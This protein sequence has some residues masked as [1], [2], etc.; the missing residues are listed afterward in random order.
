VAGPPIGLFEG[1]GYECRQ[2]QLQPGDGL[3]LFSDGVTEAMDAQDHPFG[4]AR[5][6]AVL[7]A[8]KGSPRETGERLVQAVKQHASGRSQHDDITLVCFGR[9]GA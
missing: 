6:R 8:G 3:W 4:T 5:A 7:G 1:H 9:A 2:V